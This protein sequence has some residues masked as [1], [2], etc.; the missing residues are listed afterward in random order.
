M[1]SSE[2]YKTIKMELNSAQQQTVLFNNGPLL[3]I[4]GAGSGKTKTLVHRVARLIHDNVP[5]EKI[6]LLTFTRKAA[7]EMLTRATHL[8]DHRC[9]QVSGGTFHSFANLT[10]RKYAS[11]LGYTNEFT[12]LDQSDSQ[13][14]IDQLRKGLNISLTQQRFPK[15][16]TIATIYSKHI[17]TGKSI[18]D[19]IHQ[20]YPQFSTL[21]T[22]ITQILSQYQTQKKAI[23]V[24]DYDDLLIQLQQLLRQVPDVQKELQSQYDYIMVDEYQDTNLIQAD[25]IRLLAN[26]SQ[27]VMIVGDDAQSIYGFRGAHHENIMSFPNLFPNTELIKLEENYRSCQPILDFTNALINQAKTKYSK[28][29]FTS[30]SGGDKPHYIEA[31]SENEQ[32][33]WICKEVLKLREKGIPLNDMA[34]LIRSGFHS[35]DLELELQAHQINFQKFGGFKFMEAAHIKDVVPRHGQRKNSK[36]RPPPRQA[37]RVQ[38]SGEPENG[39]A[40]HD[41]EGPRASIFRGFTGGH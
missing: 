26:Q 33:Q 22:E 11:Y 41:V 21:S 7:T 27:N 30:K 36:M 5:P 38:K 32:S 14:L 4:A 16:A 31:S 6:L 18:P 9:H 24:M 37:H 2:I 28:T 39:R 8:L 10:L 3:V 29:L 25:I 35:N 15:K 13:D 40:D 20:Q 12:I 1:E 34:I 17:N 23:N 19:I